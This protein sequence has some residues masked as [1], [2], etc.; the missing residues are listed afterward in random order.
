MAV[1]ANCLEAARSPSRHPRRPSAP[2][3]VTAAPY[4][5]IFSGIQVNH[6][7]PTP[8]D[9]AIGFPGMCRVNNERTR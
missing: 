6:L 3:A 5:G 2:R 9:K 8:G 1:F 4:Q 7:G